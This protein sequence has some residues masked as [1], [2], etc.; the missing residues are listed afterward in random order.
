MF[1]VHTISYISLPWLHQRI[2]RSSFESFKNPE[3]SLSLMVE[4]S[5]LKHSVYHIQNRYKRPYIEFPTLCLWTQICTNTVTCQEHMKNKVNKLKVCNRTPYAQVRDLPQSHCVGY[6]T[7]IIH[8]LYIYNIYIYIYIYVYIH[9]FA[10]KY[11]LPQS[12]IIYLLSFFIK[13]TKIV[14]WVN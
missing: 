10:Y 9:Y 14:L 12:F 5:A 11:M 2:W 8:I 6:Y 1:D 7:Y 13:N 3:T 4:S